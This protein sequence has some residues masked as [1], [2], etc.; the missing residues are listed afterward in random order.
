MAGMSWAKLEQG[1]N[2]KQLIASNFYGEFVFITFMTNAEKK[3]LQEDITYL[4]TTI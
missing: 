3:R 4:L 2:S 1:N